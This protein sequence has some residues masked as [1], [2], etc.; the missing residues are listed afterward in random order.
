MINKT[1]V[2]AILILALTGCQAM[3]GRTAGRNVDDATISASVK[4]RLTAEKDQAVVTLCSAGGYEGE[5]GLGPGE[6]RR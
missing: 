6:A 4:T 1:I 3:T 2:T 5:A